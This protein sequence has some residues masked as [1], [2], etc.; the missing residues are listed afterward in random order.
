MFK[1]AKGIGVIFQNRTA[2]QIHK[3][4]SISMAW[5]YDRAF[6][7]RRK[8]PACYPLDGKMMDLKGL[9]LAKGGY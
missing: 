3:L 1:G 6:F 9:E 2:K 7:V 8:D 4:D 5:E